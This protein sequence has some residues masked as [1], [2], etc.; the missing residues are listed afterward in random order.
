MALL[1]QRKTHERPTNL[2][3]QRK[4]VE[5]MT[6][7]TLHWIRRITHC[8]EKKKELEEY[9][10][11]VEAEAARAETDMS[12]LRS[13]YAEEKRRADDYLANL[14]NKLD[15]EQHERLQGQQLLENLQAELQRNAR[16]AEQAQAHLRGQIEGLK[17]RGGGGGGSR[18][19]I[20]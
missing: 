11:K 8:S 1:L 10:K 15:Q 3:Q 18:C 19:I 12:R 14:N 13:E 9:Q 2:R 6:L 17:R 5:I 7:S 20:M 4:H 16:E